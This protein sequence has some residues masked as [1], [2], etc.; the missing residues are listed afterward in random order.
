MFGDFSPEPRLT[1]RVL[2]LEED[3]NDVE[4]VIE[5]AR[6]EG[7]TRTDREG[8]EIFFIVF[9]RQP[10]RVWD[11]TEESLREYFAKPVPSYVTARQE[12]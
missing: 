9:D 2:V 3:D 4:E 7:A 5:R 8:D 11:F 6:D 10:R 12:E 1:P